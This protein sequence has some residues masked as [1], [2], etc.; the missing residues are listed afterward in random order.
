LVHDLP[1]DTD[2]LAAAA[3]G[4]AAAFQEFCVRSLPR[5]LQFVRGRCRALGLPAHH[6][7]DLTQETLLRGVQW[8][9]GHRAATIH[10]P[11]HWLMRIANNLTLSLARKHYRQPTSAL[12]D[13][14]LSNLE[15]PE[16]PPLDVVAG[17]ESMRHLL[18]QYGRLPQRDREVLEL[19]LLANH[20]LKHAAGLLHLSVAA[21]HKR[22]ER[23]L[24]RLRALITEGPPQQPP[25]REHFDRLSAPNRQI[26]ELVLLENRPI[27]EAAAVLG[28]A[29]AAAYK[30]Y[31][32]A[33]RRLRAL[34]GAPN[35]RIKP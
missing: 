20:P 35:D 28:I 11:P 22:F 32:R 8:L 31:E 7:E 6:A 26:L 5:L 1:S 12:Q 15:G 24:K 27:K 13:A 34:G 14:D 3:A 4:D 30:R 18:E 25:L 2:L 23:A 21:A 10:S 29:E 33:L 17:R 9:R 19:V 16:R